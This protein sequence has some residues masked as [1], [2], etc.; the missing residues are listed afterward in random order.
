MQ[1]SNWLVIDKE[2]G[3]INEKSTGSALLCIL[4]ENSR[5]NDTNEW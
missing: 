3:A 2:I 5:G 4:P 1:L